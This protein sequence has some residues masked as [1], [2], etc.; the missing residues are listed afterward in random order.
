MSKWALL[1]SAV[2]YKREYNSSNSIHAFDGFKNLINRKKILWK[3]FEHEIHCEDILK[4]LNENAHKMTLNE[5]SPA[6]CLT[7]IFSYF[8]KFMELSTDC[9]ECTFFVHFI[10]PNEIFILKS[11]DSILH[12]SVNFSN[13]NV[14]LSSIISNEIVVVSDDHHYWIV[15]FVSKSIIPSLR[16]CEFWSYDISTI[17]YTRKENNND[18]AV[19]I[20]TREKP[21]EARVDVKSLLSNTLYQV[22]NTGN[23]CVWPSES[24]FLYY[25]LTSYNV[26]NVVDGKSDKSLYYDIFYGKKVIELGGGTTGLCGLGLACAGF[27]CDITLTDGHP[28]CV[29]NQNVCIQMNK[30]KGFI[31]SSFPIRSEL[32]HW[33]LSNPSTIETINKWC[34][35]GLCPFQVVL[36]SDCLF[37][38]DFHDD[39]IQ[40]LLKIADPNDC[41][42]I[43]L[44][45]NR[46][47]TMQEFINKCIPYF[48]VLIED[49]YCSELTNLRQSAESI[50]SYNP[51]IHYPLLLTLKQLNR[52]I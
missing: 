3:G 40:L 23:I 48:D 49:N 11:F 28:N 26:N 2:Q 9:A 33:S 6:I 37:F 51:D 27:D 45:P 17:A 34:T 36:A 15:K 41:T 7:N 25:L 10:G 30:Q 1:K 52:K 22:D 13:K 46:D 29:L 47:C 50:N 18:E 8:E 31:Q 16:K 39:L 24:I 19:S 5:G 12:D 4:M 35:S 21:L 42:I 43:F 32:L 44:Q 38:R 20:L 14:S